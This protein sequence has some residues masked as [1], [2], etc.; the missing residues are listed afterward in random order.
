MKILMSLSHEV[1]DCETFI[2]L[3][4]PLQT[5]VQ[6]L[7]ENQAGVYPTASMTNLPFLQRQRTASRRYEMPSARIIVL[8]NI[9]LRVT[10]TLTTGIETK[11]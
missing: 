3:Q 4:R 6:G 9:L 8:T 10:L 5:P 7:R 1:E 11:G 2:T